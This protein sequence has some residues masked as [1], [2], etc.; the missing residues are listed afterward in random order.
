MEED[1]QCVWSEFWHEIFE[2][3]SRVNIRLLT[4]RITLEL[5]FEVNISIRYIVKLP[6]HFLH[7][8]LSRRF[9]RDFFTIVQYEFIA[10]SVISARVV[11]RNVL[12]FTVLTILRACKEGKEYREWIWTRSEDRKQEKKKQTCGPVKCTTNVPLTWW[13]GEMIV[14]RSFYISNDGLRYWSRGLNPFGPAKLWL[15]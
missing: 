1:L 2:V 13:Q 11:H 5:N 12:H 4:W 6:F 9:L 7:D 8:L 14:N 3:C 10:K 15:L